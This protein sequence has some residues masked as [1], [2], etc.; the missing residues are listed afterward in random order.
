MI[1]GKMSKRQAWTIWTEKKCQPPNPTTT[2]RQT[3]LSNT[4]RYFCPRNRWALEF[5]TDLTQ[6]CIPF[7]K[8]R[9]R[10]VHCDIICEKKLKVKF[11]LIS[12][13]ELWSEAHISSP[14]SMLPVIRCKLKIRARFPI[15]AWT[16]SGAF[17]EAH[18]NMYL[19]WS[20]NSSWALI[21]YTTLRWLVEP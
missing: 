21:C 10:S 1:T 8:L 16:L 5:W 6:S 11:V 9:S 12:E 19:S 4:Q 14:C 17:F 15:S 18:T 20:A 13:L 7:I 3:P 2:S